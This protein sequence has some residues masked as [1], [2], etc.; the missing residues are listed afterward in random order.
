MVRCRRLQQWYGLSDP[1]AEEA[2]NDRGSFRAFVGL[3]LDEAAP[4]HSALSRFQACWPSV[5]GSSMRAD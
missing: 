1:A 5:A 4:G 2:L 3:A